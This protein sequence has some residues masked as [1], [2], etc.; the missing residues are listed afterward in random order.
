M[1]VSDWCK[2]RL[3]V[4]QNMTEHKTKPSNTMV[5][6]GS[7][8][9]YLLDNYF[10]QPRVDYLGKFDFEIAGG[11]TGCHRMAIGGY[12]GQYSHVFSSGRAPLAAVRR[13]SVLSSHFKIWANSN[14]SVKFHHSGLV[15]SGSTSDRC[16]ASR[17]NQRY[18]RPG[19]V[20]GSPKRPKFSVCRWLWCTYEVNSDQNNDNSMKLSQFLSLSSA[21]RW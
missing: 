21:N 9:F 11:D 8:F 20:I 3:L 14:K 17:S 16:G 13:A 4:D 10:P 15:L 6:K 19:G 18:P 5:L 7:F 2:W 12:Y 1:A